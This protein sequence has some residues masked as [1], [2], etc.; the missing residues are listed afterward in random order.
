MSQP[1]LAL[2]TEGVPLGVLAHVP[3]LGRNVF[4]AVSANY[5]SVGQV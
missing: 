5:H 3:F 4:G 2:A 1:T